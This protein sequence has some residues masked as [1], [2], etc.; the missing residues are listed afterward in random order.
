MKKYTAEEMKN[1][2]FFVLYDY[3]DNFVAYFDN[4]LELIKCCGHR[5]GDYV[6]KFNHSSDNSIVLYIDNITYHLYAYTDNDLANVT[7]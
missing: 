7:I 3:F 1:K 5:V 2:Y 4:F 6:Y